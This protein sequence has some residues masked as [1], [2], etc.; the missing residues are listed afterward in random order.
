MRSLFFKIFLY[1]LLIILLVA[2]VTVILT[3]LRDQQYPSLANQDFVQRAV[4]EYGRDAIRAYE[5][6]GI[7][8]LDDYT[9]KIRRRTGILLSLFDQYGQ[10][11][12]REHQPHFRTSRI[13]EQA[14]SSGELVMPNRGMRGRQS[15]ATVIQ[16]DSGRTYVVSLLLPD[17]PS[18]ENIAKEV[19]HGFL[20]WQLLLLLVISAAICFVLARSLTAP[21]GRLR[22]AT[23]KFAAGDL[24]TR[25]GGKLKGSQ[26]LAGLA[27][28]F[29]DMA[30]KIE[31]LVAGQ[32]QLLRDISH[33]LRSPLARLGVALELARQQGK[34][35][36]RAKA[37]ER[38]ECEAERMN[39]MIGQLLSLTRLESGAAQY[40]FELFDLSGLLDRL[41]QDASYEAQKHNCQV[42][43]D[44]PE[45]VLLNGSEDLLAHAIENVIR[46]AVKYTAEQ[47]VVRVTLRQQDA[48]VHIVVDDQGPGVPEDSLD[49]LFEPFYRVADARDRQSGG[50]GI[51]L[52]IAKRAVLLHRGRIKAENRESGGL[53]VSMELPQNI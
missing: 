47:G 37:L 50:T 26:E 42:E 1:F 3:Y 31:D 34:P 40:K 15:L 25:I 13:V 29:D 9:D 28:D 45:Q 23:R 8:E 36:T 52:A 5:K 27:D 49:K 39:E 53:S 43:L 33:E 6:H 22:Q 35:E 14:L 20:G 30:T 41:V 10:P 51:G 21:I 19:T 32:K 17:K 7:K 2:G 38:I 46:N 11:L 48:V 44:A 4:A 24:S 12:S 18:P 16:A